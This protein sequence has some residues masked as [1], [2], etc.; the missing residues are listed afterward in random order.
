MAVLNA[1]PYGSGMLAKGPDAY[2]RYAYQRRAEMI[3][4]VRRYAAIAERHGFPAGRRPAVL[5]S[6]PTHDG[7]H[8]RGRPSAS[9]RSAPHDPIPDAYGIDRR[10]SVRHQ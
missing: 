3:D 9:R 7:H 10:D 5:D 6:R 2:P 4:R 8:R 1:A